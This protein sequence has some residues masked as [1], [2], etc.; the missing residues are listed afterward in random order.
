MLSRVKEYYRETNNNEESVAAGLEHTAGIITAAG[1]ILIGTFGS[2]AV[3]DILTVKEI[4]LGLA[5]GVLLDSTIVRVIMV[6]AS[7]RLAGKANWYMPAWLKKIVPEIK[8]APAGEI[9]P[10]PVPRPV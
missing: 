3:A 6:P 7:M 1:L 10:V 2:F 5:I 9:A 4:G 8:E